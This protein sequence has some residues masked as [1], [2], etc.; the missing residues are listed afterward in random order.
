MRGE[1]EKGGEEGGSRPGYERH[2][3][4]QQAM[5]PGPKD[6]GISGWKGPWRLHKPSTL[7][8]LFH[9]KDEAQ[10]NNVT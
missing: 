6:L 4:K 5:S 2:S 3:P 7:P 10:Q 9:F 8:L 1:V